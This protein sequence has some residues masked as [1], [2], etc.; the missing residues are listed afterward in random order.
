MLYTNILIVIVKMTIKRPVS[1]ASSHSLVGHIFRFQDWDDFALDL[2]L[3]G[4]KII[5]DDEVD[6]S[7]NDEDNKIVMMRMMRLTIMMTRMK[8]IT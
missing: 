2:D 7:D 4:G 8:I 6:N 5:E 3:E 1:Q